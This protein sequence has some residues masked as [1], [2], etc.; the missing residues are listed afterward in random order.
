MTTMM[1]K[2]RRMTETET[3]TGLAVVAVVGFQRQRPSLSTRTPGTMKAVDS[4]FL[5]CSSPVWP[6]PPPPQAPAAVTDPPHVLARH[7]GPARF[8]SRLVSTASPTSEGVAYQPASQPACL[9]S[10]RPPHPS[11]LSRQ[12]TFISRRCTASSTYVCNVR[13]TTAQ[14]L[15]RRELPHAPCS[16]AISS[17]TMSISVSP[18]PPTLHSPSSF[19]YTSSAFDCDNIVCGTNSSYSSRSSS[20]G[21]MDGMC[22]VLVTF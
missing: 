6:P 19:P 8:F 3:A 9:P 11:R 21:M 18:A 7:G 16:A 14:Y 20:S 10:T 13:C 4:A 5:R 2:K 1:M 12:A 17:K 15:Y 22:T